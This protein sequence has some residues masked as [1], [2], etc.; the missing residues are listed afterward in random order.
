MVIELLG[1]WMEER[2]GGWQYKIY[3]REDTVVKR[4]KS[5]F[6]MAETIARSDPTLLARPKTLLSK[7]R[8]TKRRRKQSVEKLKDHPV[9]YS[10]L[11]NVQFDGQRVIQDRVL[12]VWEVLEGASDA[13]ERWATLDRCIDCLFECWRQ[14]FA[15]DSYSFAE[16]YG[17]SGDE[18]VVI[19][20]GELCFSK[21]RI[22]DH[23]AE[24]AWLDSYTYQLL[25]PEDRE[26]FRS[27]MARRVTVEKLDSIWNVENAV[28][29]RS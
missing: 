18:A 6:E 5:T 15:E 16:N 1:G 24:E 10:L 28:T 22:E 3:L 8:R 4:P 27:E 9:D 23:I 19:D 11:A 21:E 25:A 14:G 29:S 17:I 26:Y 2:Y 20:V 13:E 12:P 7:V